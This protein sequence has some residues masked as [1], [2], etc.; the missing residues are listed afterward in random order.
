[1]PLAL[2]VVCIGMKCACLVRL[3]TTHILALYPW[4]SGSSTMKSTL[5]V[6]H[7]A[8]GVFEEWSLPIGHQHCTFVQLHE[9]QVLT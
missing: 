2:I 4:D 1:M 6:S 3:L 8:S 7:G 5:I 9:S